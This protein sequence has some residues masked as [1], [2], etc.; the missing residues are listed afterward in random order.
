MEKNFYEAAPISLLGMQVLDALIKQAFLRS[1]TWKVKNKLSKGDIFHDILD[2]LLS[3]VSI[4][5]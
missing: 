2:G 4:L 3:D 5:H 1:S